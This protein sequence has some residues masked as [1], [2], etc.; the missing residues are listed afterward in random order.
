[1]TGIP[2]RTPD[3]QTKHYELTS[4]GPKRTLGELE[5][6]CSAQTPGYVA[7]QRSTIGAP[8]DWYRGK[9]RGPLAGL[10][11]LGLTELL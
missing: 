4:W 2:P 8:H 11:T 1:M 9:P 7:A 6:A 5:P 3:S 10:S